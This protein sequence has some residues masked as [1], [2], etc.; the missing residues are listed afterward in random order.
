MFDYILLKTTKKSIVVEQTL[1]TSSHKKFITKQKNL[2]KIFS[3]RLYQNT[4]HTGPFCDM[5]IKAMYFEK[6]CLLLA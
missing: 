1:E 2:Y 6:H 3:L 4:G 5:G